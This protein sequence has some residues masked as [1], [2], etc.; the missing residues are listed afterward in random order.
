MLGLPYSDNI[1]NLKTISNAAI[2]EMF[3]Q[4]GYKETLTAISK[5][6]KPNLPATWNALFTILF[7][8]FY[9]RVTGSECESK[10]FI[11]LMYGLYTGENVVYSSILWDQ[12]I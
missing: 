2:L 12:F 8:S 6:K 11:G 9:E 7:K 5:F 4:M 1:V 10:L 3:Y